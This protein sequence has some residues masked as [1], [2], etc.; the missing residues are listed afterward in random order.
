MK[1]SLIA[2]FGGIGVCAVAWIGASQYSAGRTSADMKAFADTP[3]EKSGFRITK[4]EQKTGFLSSSGSFEIEI[5]GR[6]L[7]DNARFSANYQASHLLLPTSLARVHWKTKPE[8]KMQ[9]LLKPLFGDTLALEGDGTVGY[10]DSLSTSVTMPALSGTSEGTTLAVSP[11]SGRL[12]IKGDSVAFQG[13]IDT[14]SVKG[15]KASLD[16]AHLSMDSD[17][18]DRRT[19]IGR[20]SLTIG[21]VAVGEDVADGLK[22]ES[23]VTRKTDKLHV[24]MVYTVGSAK[25]SG[26]AAKDLALEITADGMDAEASATMGDIVRASDGLRTLTA[27]DETRLR[28]AV[29]ALLTKGLSLGITRMGGTIG[30]GTLDAKLL[31]ELRPADATAAGAPLPIARQFRASGQAKLTGPVLSDQQKAIA[32]ATGTVEEVPGGGLQA[33][34]D[35]ADNALKLNGR[36]SDARG[37]VSI[38]AMTE[39]RINA[40]LAGSLSL[41]GVMDPGPAMETGTPGSD[42]DTADD[43]PDD[44]EDKTGDAHK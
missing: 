24:T 31:F 4:L 27:E 26:T 2:T 6:G 35:F 7:T 36:Q 13:A 40:F 12:R 5:L 20:S 1:K 22:F 23:Q 38:L 41:V 39:Q 32:M 17:I 28:P 9:E 43:G 25:V 19:G 34:F 37:I 44:G 14:V 30:T 15:D 29:R 33:A 8:G 11:L 18:E 3:A 10:D 42:E 21:H 16:V